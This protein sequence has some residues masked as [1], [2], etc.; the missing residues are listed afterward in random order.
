MKKS[1][2]L[3]LVFLLTLPVSVYALGGISDAV[4][5]LAD[6]LHDT[7]EEVTTVT[8]RIEAQSSDIWDFEIND[9]YIP[10]KGGI[11]VCKA[12]NTVIIGFYLSQENMDFYNQR[13]SNGTRKPLGFEMVI[14]DH[15]KVFR[16]GNLS[17][18]TYDPNTADIWGVRYNEVYTS[19]TTFDRYTLCISD[20]TKLQVNK[21]YTVAFHFYGHQEFEHNST[22]E[23]QVQLVGNLYKLK[24]DF[25]NLYGQY[26]ADVTDWVNRFFF[27]ADNVG[28]PTVVNGNNYFN[29]R[30]PAESRFYSV[31]FFG[32]PEGE[33]G[34]D[35]YLWNRYDK[36]G[37]H[38]CGNNKGQVCD[39]Q[40]YSC[41]FGSD[42]WDSVAYNPV[43]PEDDV[44][45]AGA[46]SW[47]WEDVYTPG[48]DPSNETGGDP[49]YVVRET[50]IAHHKKILRPGEDTEI[51]TRIK[52]QG[53]A[54]S[55]QD[56]GLKYW[57][58]DGNS[59][60]PK[61][62]RV[63]LGTDNIQ[64]ENLSPGESKWESKHVQAPSTPGTYNFTVE[65]DHDEDIGE[66]HESNNKFDPPFVFQVK[67]TQLF[68]SS[69][70]I[71]GGGT[72]FDPGTMLQVKAYTD[73]TGAEPGSDAKLFYY[74]DGA[75]VGED[76]MR[77]Y[78]L[79]PEDIPKEE[80][81]YIAVPQT[82]G[83]HV[84]SARIDPLNSIDETNEADNYA[85]IVL[86]VRDLAPPQ[87]QP[88]PLAPK[89][90]GFV[91]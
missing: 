36:N 1:T 65:V 7:V 52:N 44:V 39:Y 42:P 27:V 21:W 86:T 2:F 32:W 64:G 11:K 15:D 23:V 37:Q 55:S 85:Q 74:L 59:I 12:E 80:Y 53:D 24:S 3:V 84:I 38:Y 54:T 9:D 57:R 90:F 82:P 68:F 33:E 60:D 50:Y 25:G 71:Y 8:D 91:E 58:S 17:H 89:N 66:I 76:S 28:D 72:A 16:R 75:K 51:F 88:D 83:T 6:L 77:N 40:P 31:N 18:Y 19:D 46:Q 79:E 48:S 41:A 43:D 87:S 47:T 69:F 4:S 10:Q 49:D 13:F 35:R 34:H 73:N 62:D 63:N 20:P 67:K 45:V 14:I 61:D 78:N 70:F 22:F 30:K 5:Y 81:I 26:T 29:V 56:I